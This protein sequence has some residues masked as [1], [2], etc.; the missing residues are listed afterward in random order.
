MTG[1]FDHLR[2]AAKVAMAPALAILGLVALAAGSYAVFEDLRRDFIYLNDTAFARFSDAVLLQASVSKAQAQLYRIIS[3]ANADDLQQAKVQLGAAEHLLAE[4]VDR[5]KARQQA[6]GDGQTAAAVAAYAKA[7]KGAI[8]MI[9]VDPGMAL[10][11]MGDVHDQFDKLSAALNEAAVTADRGRATTF[12]AALGSIERAGLG[13]VLSAVAVAVLAI[14]AT[15]LV[16]R[17]IGRPVGA[18]TGI[19]GSLAAGTLELEIPYVGRRDELGKMARAVMVFKQHAIDAVRLTAESEAEHATRERRQSVLLR[20]TQD[21]GSSI[22]GVMTS[23]SGAADGMRQAA[24][25]MSQAANAVHGEASDTSQSATKSSQDLTAVAAAVEALIVSF[26]T[27]AQQVE[28][29]ATVA[30]QAVQR[31]ESSHSTMQGLADATARIGDV[32]RL[33]SDIASQTNLPPLMLRISCY[34]RWL[35]RYLADFTHQIPMILQ[36]KPDT[37]QDKKE[38]VRVCLPIGRGSYERPLQAAGHHRRGAGTTI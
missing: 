8:D 27:I 19:M 11:L 7:A 34:I 35:G 31:A 26:S 28:V 17:A 38:L 12:A 29:A 22:A 13:F 5:A 37:V 4:S 33:I 3:L 6:S 20:H 23:L 1:W 2:I 32:V 15:V 24:A 36:S 14:V 21:F 18:L 25:A 30:R 16:T 9:S 10:L